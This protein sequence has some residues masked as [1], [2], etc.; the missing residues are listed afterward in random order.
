MFNDWSI[1]KSNTAYKIKYNAYYLLILGGENAELFRNRK[2]YFSLNVQV[3]CDH[4]LKAIDIVA[5]WPGS[6]HDATVFAHSNLHNRMEDN[7]FRS[8]ILLGDCGYPL[9]SYLLTPARNPRTPAEECYND[10]HIRTRNI[11][12]RFF[13]V[14]KRRF[15]VLS[16]GMRVKLETVQDIIVATAVLHNWARDQLEEEPPLIH[17]NIDN[18]YDV[19]IDIDP[20]RPGRLRDNAVAQAL[21]DDYFSR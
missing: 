11:I 13:G 6:V 17:E 18:G 10:T 9:K 4:N 7:H 19:N 3:V 15:P 5:R 8:G 20:D 14:W 1:N 21:I 12:E 2:G 16:I